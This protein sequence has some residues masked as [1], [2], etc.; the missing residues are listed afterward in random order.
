KTHT[1]DIAS[2]NKLRLIVDVGVD[3][4]DNHGSSFLVGG[5]EQEVATCHW[6]CLCWLAG[7]QLTVDKHLVGLWIDTN[8]RH[9]CIEFHVSFGQIPYTSNAPDLLPQIQQIRNICIDSV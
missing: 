3:R 6:H 7:D 1:D 8:I 4:S 9:F 5:L 2:F